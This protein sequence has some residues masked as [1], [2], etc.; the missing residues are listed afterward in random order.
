MSFLLLGSWYGLLLV[1][2]PIP[3]GAVRAILEDR[4]SREELPGYVAS[5]AQVTYRLIPYVG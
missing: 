4:V 2:N 5:M 3:V 1:L